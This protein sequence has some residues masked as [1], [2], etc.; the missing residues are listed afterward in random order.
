VG[1]WLGTLKASFSYLE[2][3]VF[4]A[5]VVLLRLTLDTAPRLLCRAL[6]DVQDLTGTLG[7]FLVSSISNLCLLLGLYFMGG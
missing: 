6:A 7:M 1:G 3:I 5:R 2:L 4:N